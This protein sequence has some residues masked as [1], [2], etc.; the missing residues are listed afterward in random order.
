NFRY[1]SGCHA[2]GSLMGR[3]PPAAWARAISPLRAERTLSHWFAR[4]A[5]SR[6]PFLPTRQALTSARGRGGG[7]EQTGRGGRRAGRLAGR[8]V[9]PHPRAPGAPVRGTLRG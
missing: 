4:C 6:T 9:A 7:Q 3:P 1:W 2:F 8:D 5:R